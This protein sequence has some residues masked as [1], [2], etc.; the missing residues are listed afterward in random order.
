M[1]QRARPLAPLTSHQMVK[2]PSEEAQDWTHF[3]CLFF[4][5]RKPLEKDFTLGKLAIQQGAGNE[6]MGLA[7]GGGWYALM[8][9][10]KTPL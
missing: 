9:S 7:A 3:G 4:E 5:T 8:P 6:C 1:Q 10:T 2:H